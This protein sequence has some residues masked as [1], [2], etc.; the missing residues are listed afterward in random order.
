MFHFE[1]RWLIVMNVSACVYFYIMI[2]V[3]TPWSIR[4]SASSWIDV[5]SKKICGSFRSDGL[6]LFEGEWRN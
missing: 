1:G 2:R 4:L 3:W 6:C 5:R